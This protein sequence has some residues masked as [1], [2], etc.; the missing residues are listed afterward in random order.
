M[1]A[2]YA[3]LLEAMGRGEAEIRVAIEALREDAFRTD[4]APSP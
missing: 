3:G 4:P 1:I 2:N